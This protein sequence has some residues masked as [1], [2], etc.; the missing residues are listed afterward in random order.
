MRISIIGAAV[1]WMTATACVPGPDELAAKD[2]DIDIAGRVP[3][4]SDDQLASVLAQVAYVK[5]SNPDRAD[6]FGQSVALSGDTL[7]VGA[8]SERSA[9]TGI[10]GNQ[11]DNSVA[12]AGAVYVFVR[13][14]QTWSQQAYIK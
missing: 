14:G 3:G 6:N 11:A 13:D 5:A 10:N 7:V 8:P 2:H 9:A 4:A 12:R 1:S